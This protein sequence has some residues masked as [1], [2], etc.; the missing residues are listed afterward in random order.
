MDQILRQRELIKLVGLSRVSLWR[1]ERL[2]LFPQRRRIGRH[3]IGWL[4]SD[5]DAWLAT[6]PRGPQPVRQDAP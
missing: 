5:I 2:G 3:A 1:L 4:K 6:R